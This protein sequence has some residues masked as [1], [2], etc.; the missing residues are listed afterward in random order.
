MK[1]FG[2]MVAG[3]VFSFM[4]I[5][6][7]IF[8]AVYGLMQ[9]DKPANIATA[10]SLVETL[11]QRWQ[12]ADIAGEF[13]PV[14]LATIDDD[15]AQRAIDPFRRLGRLVSVR[16]TKISDYKVSY[17]DQDGFHRRATL[18]LVGAFEDGE[19]Q[20]TLIL[21]TRRGVSKVQHMNIKPVRLPPIE[22][23]RRL[24]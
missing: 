1:K 3:A 24:A 5:S 7:G 6:A 15:A 14:V 19:A 13:R 18:T 17:T 4:L 16:D 22:Q 21:V 8:G 23:R 2:K 10:E 9:R 20:I 12:F 11:S